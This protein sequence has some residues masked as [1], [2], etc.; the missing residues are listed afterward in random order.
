MIVMPQ[1]ATRRMYEVF[2]EV[3]SNRP[4]QVLERVVG[5]RL[6]YCTRTNIREHRFF[7]SID[8]DALERKEIEAP[9]VPNVVSCILVLV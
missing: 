6:G 1:R 4:L 7:R 8:W 3:K 9:F 5:N 2:L